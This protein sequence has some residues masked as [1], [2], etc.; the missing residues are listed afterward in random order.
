MD[1]LANAWLRP[2]QSS[3]RAIYFDFA[4]LIG[5]ALLLIA[6]GIGLRDPWPA[7]EPRFALIARDMV[8]SGD[9]LVPRVGGDLYADKPPLYFWLL[10]LSLTA[11]GSPRIAF[12]L[13]SLLSAI[14]CIVLVYDLARRMWSREVGLIAGTLL[15]LTAQFVWQ[16]RQAQI[17]ATLCFFTTLSLYG[18]MRHLLLGPSWRWHAVGWAA[19]GCG[20]ITKGVGFL[21]LLILVPW[22]V[23]RARWRI[24]F[25]PVH[26]AK[27]LAGPLAFIG[28]VSSWLVPMLFAARADLA[29]AAYRDEILF[30]QTAARYVDAWHHVRPFWYFI[31]QVI[32]LLWLPLIALLPWLVPRWREAWRG[33]DP[34]VVLPLL[35]AAIV[36]VFFSLSAGKRGVYVLPALPAFVLACAPYLSELSRI[37][38]V[39]R[40]VFGLAVATGIACAGAV[41][42]AHFA[43]TLRAQLIATYGL[44]A[45][46]PALLIAST[47][48]VLAVLLR[49]RYAFVAYGGVILG[50][51]LVVSFWVNPAMNDARSGARFV[52]QLERAAHA[53]LELGLVGFREEHLLYIQRPVVHFGHARWR[54]R[55]AETFDAAS[56]MAARTGRQLLVDDYSRSL[57]FARAD[58]LALG[59]DKRRSWYLVTGQPDSNCAARGNLT[60]ALRYEPSV[61]VRS[62]SNDETHE[63]RAEPGAVS[64][65]RVTKHGQ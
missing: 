54:E 65:E 58:A 46:G 32:P 12:L 37:A 27:W 29:L 34:R 43:E 52:R 49:P 25:P 50:A 7:D 18:L 36:V 26:A 47:A 40:V 4:W 11:T 22:L 23:L 3:A 51:L 19:A 39:R 59:E 15:L 33:R 20:V 45:I 28:V 14:G 56:W 13:P 57:C 21:P 24:G 48:I 63:L 55:E 53:D 8:T 42:Y 30:V 35:W 60:A 6:T 10:A 31:A 9:W 16:A 44:D 1:G 64:A 5:L 2:S 38:N 62:S 61:Q 41:V 17:D